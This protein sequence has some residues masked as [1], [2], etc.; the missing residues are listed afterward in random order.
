M[1][2]I[3]SNKIFKPFAQALIREFVKYPFSRDVLNFLYL[4]LTYSQMTKVHD[5]FAKIFRDTNTNIIP[6]DWKVVFLGREI[7]IPLKTETIWLDWDTALSIIGHD[8]EVKETYQFF[9]SQENK[10]D[11][12]VDIGTNYG[13][14][15]LLFLCHGIETISFE[16]NSSCH[17]YFQEMSIFNNVKVNLEKVALGET[18]GVV[19]IK[20]PEK[21]TWLG[22]T[23]E[24]IQ[25]KLGINQKMIEEEVR[26]TKLDDYI[27]QFKEKQ[28]LIKVDTEGNEF[29]VLKGAENV[30]KICKPMIIFE[31][32]NNQVKRKP[33]YNYFTS[34]GY[35]I[36]H[37]PYK[38][39]KQDNALTDDEFLTTPL[40]NFIGISQ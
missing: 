9:L 36:Y 22:S 38:H 1:N 8:T 3:V 21:A 29:S 27:D 28:V 19:T 30:L 24:T 35:Q 31:C 18:E 2:K 6:G 23:D 12:F 39:L 5:I 16:P 32:L 40:T 20:Y 15:S 37:L 4:K 7:F 17:S 34:N 26:K 11:L 33:L 13:T 25:S 14:H 10:P